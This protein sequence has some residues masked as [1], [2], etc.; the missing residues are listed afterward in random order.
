MLNYNCERVLKSMNPN[1]VPRTIYYH[2]HV[3]RTKQTICS[4]LKMLSYFSL[5]RPQFF[6]NLC[7]MYIYIYLYTYIYLIFTDLNKREVD[8]REN[9]SVNLKLC[10]FSVLSFLEVY[11]STRYQIWVLGFENAF[12]GVL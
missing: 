2:F 9:T 7:K 11:Y 4:I 1:L 12:A 6:Y 3:K 10:I 8:I 5:S